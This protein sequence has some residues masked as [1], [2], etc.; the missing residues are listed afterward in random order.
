VPTSIFFG[1]QAV[2]QGPASAVKMAGRSPRHTAADPARWARWEVPCPISDAEIHRAK[3]RKHRKARMDQRTR[4]R[5]PVLPVLIRVTAER[6][7]A[8]HWYGSRLTP[9]RKLMFLWCPSS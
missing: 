9:R 7:L 8:A 6:R 1:R 5:L 2:S 4:E 3:E